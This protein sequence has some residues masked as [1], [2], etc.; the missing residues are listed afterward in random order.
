MNK[1]Y[2]GDNLE[3]LSGDYIPDESVDLIY[4]DPPFNSQA[5]YNLLFKTPEADATAAQVEAFRD[6]WTWLEEASWAYQE[7][8]RGGGAVAR[9]IEALHSA[10]GESDMMAYLVM[11]AVRLKQLQRKLKPSG[12]LY[13]HCDP[14]A[15]HYL[16]VILDAVFGPEN[17][18]NEIIWRRTGSHNNAKRFG[19]IHDVIHF[20]R[21]SDAYEHR[22]VFRPYT[23]GH[24][25]SYFRQEDDRGRY[26]TNSLHGA[27]TRNGES[28][29][30]WRGYNP[31]DNGRH[32]AVPSE[33]VE[34]V[35]IDSGLGQHEK[36]DAL[37]D[38]GVIDLPDPSNGALPTYR[39]Y[40]D[41]SPGL[42]LQDVWA[43]QPHTQGVLY[44]SDEAIDEDVRWIPLQARGEHTERIGYP[45][46]KPIG[47][48]RRI[49]AAS[50]RE[51]D[52]ILDPFC[53]CGTTVE[54]AERMQREWIGIDIAIHAIKVIEARLAD[55]LGRVSYGL[56]GIP[57][58]FESAVRLAERDK[59]Q[60]QWWANY[61]F[62]PHALREQKKGAD[63]GIDGELFFPNG[64]GRPW[65]RLLTSVK[66][67]DNL[68]PS[69][70]RDFGHVLTREHAQMGLF[71]CLR[72]PTRQM[73]REAV[74]AGM[75]DTVHGDIPKLQIVSIEEWFQ[76]KM[77]ALPPL[78]HLPTA[79]FATV[80][81]RR[82]VAAPQPDATQPELPLPI[83]GGAAK[84][85]K[86]YLNPA[87]VRP[88]PKSRRS[89]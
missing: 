36:L 86:R 73:E 35:G 1:L 11:M 81:R 87:M 50:S 88:E 38:L 29:Q 31:T 16:K 77:P 44:S 85:S 84:G 4:L 21:K 2:F 61:L 70:I 45:T 33:L 23:K 8:M 37:A 71:I 39:Q 78:E 68:N 65:G 58:D 22:S 63:R 25:E 75:A 52:V 7:I 9:F 42:L 43:Y 53:G 62:N 66:G 89:A 26:W 74:S 40:L 57:R 3:I 54:T 19:P 6:T 27:G 47:L 51:G 41:R 30:P 56:E 80:R 15:S 69:M 67:G 72:K 24:V 46:Q 17:Y 55:R 10:L 12:A 49:L 76:G 60:F 79:A 32:W 64:P 48:L 20:Y 83:P 28:G 14:T 13:L 82:R 59:Y 18:M 5:Q 34:A